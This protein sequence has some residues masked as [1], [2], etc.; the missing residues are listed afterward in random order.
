MQLFYKAKQH[1]VFLRLKM[2]VEGV[3][4]GAMDFAKV[5]I[6]SGGMAKR[7]FDNIERDYK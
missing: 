7:A 4:L 5:G 6:S 2:G 1:K 3:D